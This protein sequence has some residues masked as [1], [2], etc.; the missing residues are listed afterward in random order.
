MGGH[1]GARGLKT[2]IL[3]RGKCRSAGVLGVVNSAAPGFRG[4]LPSWAVLRSKNWPLT[5]V[6]TFILQN[7]TRR[8]CKTLI[9]AGALRCDICLPILVNDT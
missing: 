3:G 2:A 8:S 5:M 6:N 7:K 9:S 4:L 1:I